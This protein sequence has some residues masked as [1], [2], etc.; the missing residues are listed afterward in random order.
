M[1]PFLC[2]FFAVAS[3]PLIMIK[4]YGWP[5]NDKVIAPRME[6]A[7]KWYKMNPYAKEGGMLTGWHLDKKDPNRPRQITLPYVSRFGK[8]R[9]P[10]KYHIENYGLVYE[11]S[12]TAK[13]LDMTYARL[14]KTK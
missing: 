12:E 6:E 2:L 4:V 7:V 1:F 11:G 8:G 5:V 3:R 9:W 10:F 13:I 14:E